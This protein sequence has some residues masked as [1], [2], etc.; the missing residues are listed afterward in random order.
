[1]YSHLTIVEK[2]VRK[3]IPFIFVSFTEIIE[4]VLEVGKNT[5]SELLSQARD[6]QLEKKT[7]KEM[8]VILE[9]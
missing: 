2:F 7:L 3:V 9:K 6:A 5:M 4:R 8:L 1:M